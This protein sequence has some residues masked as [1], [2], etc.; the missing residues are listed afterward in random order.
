MVASR[1]RCQDLL[2]DM[3]WMHRWIAQL[4]MRSPIQKAYQK[5]ERPVGPA[6]HAQKAQ[7]AQRVRGAKAGP[8]ATSGRVNKSDSLSLP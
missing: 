3:G 5:F 6:G 7:K 1:S 2:V 4:L 8:K